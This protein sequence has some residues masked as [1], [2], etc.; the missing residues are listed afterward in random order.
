MYEKITSCTDR[1]NSVSSLRVIL[2]GAR[3]GRSGRGDTGEGKR[4]MNGSERPVDTP[5][6]RAT[7]LL[8]K[9]DF[10]FPFFSQPSRV[11]PLADSLWG[12]AGRRPSRSRAAK[13]S[14][15]RFYESASPPPPPVSYRQL[16]NACTHA[17]TISLTPG[18]WA[19]RARD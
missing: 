8:K 6:K 13:A 14:P 2:G 18:P 16:T 12:V 7:T 9:H 19:G 17:P 10:A 4:L 11:L 5:S 3:P 1:R 15:A